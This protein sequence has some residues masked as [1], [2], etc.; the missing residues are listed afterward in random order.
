VP[1]DHLLPSA[2]NPAP[3]SDKAG[4][5]EKVALYRH[6][7]K[8]PHIPGGVNPPQVQA[9]RKDFEL[10]AAIKHD[11]PQEVTQAQYQGHVEGAST[12]YGFSLGTDRKR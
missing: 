12:G 11:V 7:V 10:I 2:S 1:F 9:G 4:S 6:A 5:A 8:A 3:N